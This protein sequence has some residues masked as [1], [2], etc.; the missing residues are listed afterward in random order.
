MN[1]GVY[2][3]GVFMLRGYKG[4][5]GMW[6]RMEDCSGGNLT[7]GGILGGNRFVS[8]TNQSVGLQIACVHNNNTINVVGRYQSDIRLESKPNS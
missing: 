6:M 5:I 7:G 3:L 2:M 8:Y 4:S 1:L